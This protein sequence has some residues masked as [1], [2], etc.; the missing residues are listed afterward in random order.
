MWTPATVLGAL[1]SHR[2]DLRR[3]GVR[4]IGLFG[5]AARGDATEESDLDFLVD[6]EPKT[7]DGYMELKELLERWFGRRVDLV[8]SDAL[9]PALRAAVLREARYAP[10]L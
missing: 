10:D 1:E 9:K 7:F 3:L 6:L 2:D 8:L 4:R 5:S